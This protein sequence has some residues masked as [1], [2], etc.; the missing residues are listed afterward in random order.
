MMNSPKAN[1][2]TSF[3]FTAK[4]DPCRGSAPS[5]GMKRTREQRKA[6]NK[7]PRGLG[8]AAVGVAAVTWWVETINIVDSL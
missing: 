6:I 7:S 4:D 1:A 8:V 2:A 3:R 5:R